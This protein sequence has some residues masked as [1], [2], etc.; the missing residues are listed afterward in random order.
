MKRGDPLIV[1]SQT[2]DGLRRATFRHGPRSWNN[3]GNPDFA[4]HYVDD[5]TT[6]YTHSYESEGTLWIKGDDLDSPEAHALLTAFHL[7]YRMQ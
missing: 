3:N 7:A 6:I 2:T 4:Y 1:W 5:P